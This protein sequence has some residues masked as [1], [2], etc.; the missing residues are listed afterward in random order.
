MT[1]P[2]PPKPFSG[3]IKPILTPLQVRFLRDCYKVYMA[4]R[5]AAGH[6]GAERFVMKRLAERFKISRRTLTSVVKNERWRHL[7]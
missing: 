1:K 6:K 7:R 3:V 4:E 5:H 2:K